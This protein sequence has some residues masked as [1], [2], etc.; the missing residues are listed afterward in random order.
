MTKHTCIIEISDYD[1]KEL[2][3]AVEKNCEMTRLF[4]PEDLERAIQRIAADF[5]SQTESKTLDEQVDYAKAMFGWALFIGICM[6]AGKKAH[7]SRFEDG[8][9]C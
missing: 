3:N 7:I 1:F 8:Q 4:W 2:Q 6:G 9:V 5:I